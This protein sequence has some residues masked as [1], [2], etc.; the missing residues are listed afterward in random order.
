MVYEYYLGCTE[1][2]VYFISVSRPQGFP[3]LSSPPPFQVLTS[4][5]LCLLCQVSQVLALALT[6]LAAGRGEWHRAVLWADVAG[7]TKKH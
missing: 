1:H 7:S 4:L 6:M 2:V 5:R 3:A